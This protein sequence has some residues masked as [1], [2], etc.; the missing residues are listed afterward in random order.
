MKLVRLSTQ[1]LP[2]ELQRLLAPAYKSGSEC[3]H[4]ACGV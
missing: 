2:T 3:D 1:A 4:L